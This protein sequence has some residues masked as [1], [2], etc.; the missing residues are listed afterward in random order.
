MMSD[1]NPSTERSREPDCR[2]VIRRLWD[3]LDGRVEETE[4]E[5]I[6]AHLEWCHGCASHYQFEREFL[7]AVGRLR[8]DDQ[9]Y[10]ALRSQI[11]ARLNTLGFSKED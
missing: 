3:F 8:R 1:S 10:D 9:D 11:T 6:V 2:H 7:S 4:R 5:Q